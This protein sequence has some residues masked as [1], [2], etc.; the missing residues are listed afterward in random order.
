MGRESFFLCLGEI[1]VW[2]VSIDLQISKDPDIRVPV[3]LSIL[4]RGKLRH[5]EV[6]THMH[7]SFPYL[8][9]D[10]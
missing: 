5:R 3:S 9:K 2:P 6:Y 4:Y 1:T 8:S 7:S 10:K